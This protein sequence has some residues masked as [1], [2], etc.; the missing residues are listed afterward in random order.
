M[1]TQQSKRD[2]LRVELCQMSVSMG[3]FNLVLQSDLNFSD[4]QY[5]RELRV[6]LNER[7]TATITALNDINRGL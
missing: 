1:K 5:F 3:A 4:K 6:Q 2:K 7:I